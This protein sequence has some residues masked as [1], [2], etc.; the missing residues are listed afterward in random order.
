MSAEQHGPRRQLTLA[1]ARD[2]LPA[3]VHDVARHGPVELTEGGEAVAV[4]VALDEYRQLAGDRP[5]FCDALQKLRAETDLDELDIDSVL[6]DVRDRSP[7][8]DVEL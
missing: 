3:I 2:Q 1:Q 7:G 8:R 4:I 6:R 5:G